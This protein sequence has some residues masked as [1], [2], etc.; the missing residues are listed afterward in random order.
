[1]PSTLLLYTLLF[2]TGAVLGSFLALT[3]CRYRAALTPAAWL[4]VICRPSSHCRQCK[5]ALH[6]VDRLP[7]I[8]QLWLRG[9]CRYCGSAVGWHSFLFEASTALLLLFITVREGLTPHALFQVGTGFLLLLLADI[10]RRTFHLPD[11][12]NYTLL[13]TGLVYSLHPDASLTPA[14]AITGALAGYLILWLL[15]TGYKLCRRK[16][17]LGYGDMKLMAAL[18]ACCGIKALP[19][20]TVCATL[21]ALGF[22]VVLKLMKKTKNRN[23]PLPFGPFLAIAGWVEIVFQHSVTLLL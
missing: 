10:D 4:N 23:S 5:R 6:F 2:F 19:L 22:V 17:G 7:L 9:E 12:L 13:W 14:D 11:P 1:M 18:G 15:A 21:L 8:S 16:E 20:V 3:S